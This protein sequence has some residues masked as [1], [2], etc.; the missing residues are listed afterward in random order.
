MMVEKHDGGVSSCGSVP[1]FNAFYP[2]DFESVVH[3]F[4]LLPL[5]FLKNYFLF[6]RL[7]FCDIQLLKPRKPSE[8]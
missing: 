3:F 5:C 4:I 6:V 7:F 1:G 2:A 8:C